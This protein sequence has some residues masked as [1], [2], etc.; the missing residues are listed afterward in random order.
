MEC[1]N[2]NKNISEDSKFCVHCG[3]KVKKEVVVKEKI[4]NNVLTDIKN[5]L[6]FVGYE[7][8]K[9]EIES[10]G[11]V[12]TLVNH[13]SRSNLFISYFPSVNLFIFTANYSV[14]KVLEKDKAKFLETI[15]HFNN[16]SFM[17][18]CYT[19]DALDVFSTSSWYPN[20]YFKKDFSN[21][22]DLFENETVAKIRHDDFQKYIG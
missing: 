3:E 18:T 15:N 13:I 17:V 6:E 21:F 1:N 14:K 4:P 9:D 11:V 2:C 10:N 22:I 12:R 8:G 20:I 16:T 5:H 7:I 19:N